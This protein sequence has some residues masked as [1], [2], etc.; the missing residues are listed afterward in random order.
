VAT[1]NSQGIAQAT[2]AVNYSGTATATVAAT[3]LLPAAS[4]SVFFEVPSRVTLSVAHPVASVGGV[5]VYRAAGAVR[6]VA[7]SRP[8]GTNHLELRLY[9]KIG[10]QWV[11]RLDQSLKTNALGD[12]VVHLPALVK[13]HVYREVIFAGP[14]ANNA[15]SPRQT[16]TFEIR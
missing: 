4:V 5:S 2:I 12:A 16:F 13:K 1:T 11:L 15:T 14:T 6:L 8:I 10:G 9:R 3:D 7:H